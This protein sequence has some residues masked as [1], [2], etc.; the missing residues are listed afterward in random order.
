MINLPVLTHGSLFFTIIEMYPE[1][2]YVDAGDYPLAEALAYF[3]LGYQLALNVLYLQMGRPL[4]LYRC[5]DVLLY[6]T[7]PYRISGEFA[8]EWLFQTIT[9]AVQCFEFASATPQLAHTSRFNAQVIQL[10]QA[11]SLAERVQQLDQLKQ[12]TNQYKSSSSV[13]QFKLMTLRLAHLNS[14]NPEYPLARQATE[15]IFINEAGLAGICITAQERA[16]ALALR[17][18]LNPG[19]DAS[20]CRQ[21]PPR[22]DYSAV[23]WRQ[24]LVQWLW[25][26][27]YP[28]LNPEPIQLGCEP[29]FASVWNPSASWEVHDLKTRTGLA[30]KLD[31]ITLWDLATLETGTIQGAL[32]QLRPGGML[33][34]AVPRT[35]HEPEAVREHMESLTQSTCYLVDREAFS[36]VLIAYVIKGHY[37][38]PSLRVLILMR[39]DSV[40]TFGGA[41][42]QM[43]RSRAY[44]KHDGIRSDI[45]LGLR[46]DAAHYDLVFVV[47]Y[48][49]EEY[50]LN[51]LSKIT[52]PKVAMPIMTLY[53]DSIALFDH[54]YSELKPFLKEPNDAQLL[55]QWQS[56]VTQYLSPTHDEIP[57]LNENGYETA[58]YNRLRQT[59][60]FFVF[61][62]AAEAPIWWG[63]K[64]TEDKPFKE[65][66]NGCYLELIEQV[67]PTLFESTYQLKDFVL[68]I[69]RFDNNKNQALVC[70][71]LSDTDIPIVLIG[72]ESEHADRPRLFQLLNPNVHILENLSTEMLFSAIKSARLLVIPS[73]NE[74]SP[75][76]AI[77][78]AW[79][80][81]PIVMTNYTLQAEWFGEGCYVCD[82][83]NSLQFKAVLLQA[84]QTDNSQKVQQA[85]ERV[86]YCTWEQVAQQLVKV[87]KQFH[88]WNE[89][90]H[91]R[92]WQGKLYEHCRN[93]TDTSFSTPWGHFFELT[94]ISPLT[95]LEPQIQ[96]NLQ[97]QGS[98]VMV[99]S[100]WAERHLRQT[101]WDNILRKTYPLEKN[102]LTY[103]AQPTVLDDLQNFNV[104]C[105]Y[106]PENQTGWQESLRAYLTLFKSTDDVALFMYC[107][108]DQDM[109]KV[110]A[111]LLQVITGHD[112]NPENIPAVVLL[113]ELFTSLDLLDLMTTMDGLLLPLHQFEWLQLWLEMAALTPVH[114]ISHDFGLWKQRQAFTAL[115]SLDDLLHLS[116]QDPIPV[117]QEMLQ[118]AL[119]ALRDKK[120]KR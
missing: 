51:C 19:L 15:P 2:R 18:Q 3:E 84:C 40:I 78:A 58:C 22:P 64:A 8:Q 116:P 81:C 32:N 110:E 17:W 73:A 33:A 61:Q 91:P 120:T 74:V 68:C 35:T 62:S 41:D 59:C 24:P 45:S 76:V 63:T 13:H 60:D 77:E 96:Q 10:L 6:S 69:G 46:L 89:I 16:E 52:L 67:S 4:Q 28:A 95:A 87:F 107:K 12:Q 80:R 104:L 86:Q 5:T 11:E 119:L 1:L 90:P 111:S 29:S 98:V 70:D 106:D 65:I 101:G 53:Q 21:T 26:A 82:P 114:I 94:T 49:H 115:A 93:L 39:T 50:K 23:T 102:W 7:Y 47:G 72:K 113:N 42:L 75:L 44:F 14:L 25:E 97:A 20:P 85:W 36:D 117:N 71:A 43:M 55:N 99:V 37:F 88:S 54:F 109:E 48:W 118:S 56:L 105:I 103:I 30:Q 27:E 112:H 100:E 83:L 34:V 92:W 66:P 38:K 9:L 79:A 31:V 57:I 108:S